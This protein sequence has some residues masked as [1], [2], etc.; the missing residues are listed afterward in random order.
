VTNPGMVGAG[1][2][3]SPITVSGPLAEDEPEG[4]IPPSPLWAMKIS[5]HFQWT[6]LLTGDDGPGRIRQQV[7]TGDGALYVMDDGHHHCIV[8]R[9]VGQ[10]GDGCSYSLV[11]RI[12][13]AQYEALAD[14]SVTA[15]DVLAQGKG[16]A[17]YGVVDDGPASNVFLLGTFGATAEVPEDYLP[18]HPP[19]AFPADLDEF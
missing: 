5:R 12:P 19:I 11:A 9:H 7:G 16:R 10:T 14:G 8:G 3:G 2:A 13:K 1:D 4:V 17:L 15:H 18:P 6:H